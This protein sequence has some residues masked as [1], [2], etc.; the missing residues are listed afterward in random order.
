MHHTPP[1]F[2]RHDNLH[3]Q[4][5]SN[6]FNI[7]KYNKPGIRRKLRMGSVANFLKSILQVRT[8]K[9]HSKLFKH[10]DKSI[11]K[12]ML[13]NANLETPLLDCHTHLNHFVA[14]KM[15]ARSSHIMGNSAFLII[16]TD[17]NNVI[18]Q[19]I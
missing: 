16:T 10:Q 11:R 7:H 19:L 13:F 9:L 17:N 15:V 18:N 6:I 12:Q 4:P 2:Q 14:N 1:S 3:H 8:I 5:Q